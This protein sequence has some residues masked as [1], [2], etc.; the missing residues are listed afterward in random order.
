MILEL[1]REKQERPLDPAVTLRLLS[2]C[3]GCHGKDAVLCMA[4]F[5]GSY[6]SFGRL[7]IQ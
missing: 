3:L 1:C 6:W 2:K 7:R 4:Q 5:R